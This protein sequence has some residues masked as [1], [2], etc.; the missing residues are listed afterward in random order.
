[1]IFGPPD[2]E[3]QNAIMED[4]LTL[5][6]GKDHYDPK[7][8]ILDEIGMM[9]FQKEPVLLR[10]TNLKLRDDGD[11]DVT[12]SEINMFNTPFRKV[13]IRNSKTQLLKEIKVYR[14]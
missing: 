3:L 4:N 1:M 7:E 14:S 2:F 10:G 13:K 5:I 9:E 11:F 8:D 12:N 6:C